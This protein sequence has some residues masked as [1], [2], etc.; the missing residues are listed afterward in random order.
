MTTPLHAAIRRCG[1]AA[2]LTVD[3][4]IHEAHSEAA[5]C[6]ETW[7]A[8]LRS[9]S[10]DRLGYA[11]GDRVT[12]GD[13]YLDDVLDD[14]YRVCDEED[15]DLADVVVRSLGYAHGDPSSFFYLARVEIAPAYRGLGLGQWIAAELIGRLGDD[16]LVTLV[17]GFPEGS[18]NAHTP[19]ELAAVDRLV[20]GLPLER[21]GA[22]RVF[23]KVIGRGA[24]EQALRTAT[25]RILGIEAVA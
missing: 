17:A 21:L 22:T 18:P 10:G 20:A 23:S 3:H 4:E 8:T 19:A 16:V 11:T 5:I 13:E 9:P 24:A 15:G 25:G 7:T 1:P 12:W 6:I 2:A 14:V